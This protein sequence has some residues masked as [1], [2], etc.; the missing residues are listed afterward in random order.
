MFRRTAGNLLQLEQHGESQSFANFQK[1]QVKLAAERLHRRLSPLANPDFEEKDRMIQ[2]E[3]IISK[4]AQLGN[5]LLLQPATF[6]F[7]WSSRLKYVSSSGSSNDH[8]RGKSRRDWRY[9]TFPA[10]LKRGDNT[11]RQLR[12]PELF[13]EPNCFDEDDMAEETHAQYHR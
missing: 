11:G 7:E 6:E 10:L 13:C 3:A 1:T 5:L 2:L 4:I 9:I 8:L 12:R